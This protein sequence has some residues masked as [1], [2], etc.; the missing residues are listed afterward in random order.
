MRCENS[1]PEAKSRTVI[2]LFGY[3]RRYLL[4]L[5]ELWWPAFWRCMNGKQMTR[6]R[7]VYGCLLEISSTI[8]HFHRIWVPSIEKIAIG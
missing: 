8:G 5:E 3:P 2:T 6:D 7:G 4:K 1:R